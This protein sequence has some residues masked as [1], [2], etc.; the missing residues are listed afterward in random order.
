MKQ[1]VVFGF[2]GSKRDAGNTQARWETWRPT[3]ALG[4]YQDLH[5]DQLELFYS[6]EDKPLLDNVVADLRAVSQRLVVVPNSMPFDDPWDFE[7][8]YAKLFDFMKAY[9]FDLESEEYLIHI[10]TGTHALQICYFLLT[11]ARFFPGKLLQSFPPRPD[12]PEEKKL[13]APTKS[14]TLISRNMNNSQ[15]DLPKI[16]R[17]RPHFSNRELRHAT[18]HSTN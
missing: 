12:R 10:K 2:L 14:S 5:V 16:Y 15:H 13:S 11:E 6:P 18:G 8:V 4:M 1:K 7:E 9:R 3:V 17:N